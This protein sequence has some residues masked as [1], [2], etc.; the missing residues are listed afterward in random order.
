[1]TF[2]DMGQWS[3]ELKTL[4]GNTNMKT[5]VEIRSGLSGFTGSETFTKYQPGI[6]LTEG[7]LWLAKEAECFWLLDII[8]SYQHQPKVKAEDL[9]VWQ[10][11]V[12]DSS[13]HVQLEDGNDNIVLGQAIQWTD[14]PLSEGITL[15]AVRNETGGVTVMLPSEY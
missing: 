9:Q 5:P 7:A 14:F 13:G 8:W 11:G 10:L 15:W 12:H 4:T 3:S 2:A 6:L 1:M